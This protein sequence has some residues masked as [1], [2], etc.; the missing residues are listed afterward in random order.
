MALHDVT[1]QGIANPKRRLEVHGVARLERTEGRPPERL[2]HYVEGD[3]SLLSFHD[4]EADACDRY[5]VAD[6]R[7]RRSLGALDDQPRAIEGYE[8]SDLAHDPGEHAT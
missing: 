5:G 4:R 1:A 6:R 2:G 7:A 8:G 3:L